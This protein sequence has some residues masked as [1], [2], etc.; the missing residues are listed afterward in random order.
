MSAP[1]KC[2]VLKKDLKASIHVNINTH[3]WQDTAAYIKG[4]TGIPVEDTQVGVHGFLLFLGDVWFFPNTL[5]YFGSF[6]GLYYS[7]MA[8]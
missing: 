2:L 4:A 3:V 8:N 6:L 7:K 1:G 5:L